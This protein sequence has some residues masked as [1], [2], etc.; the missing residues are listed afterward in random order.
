MESVEPQQLESVEPQQEKSTKPQQMEEPTEQQ[1]VEDVIQSQGDSNDPSDSTP[2][3]DP[4]DLDLELEP[5]RVASEFC[6]Y[7]EE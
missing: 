3:S 6:S 7:D 1:D 4:D 2:S 5:V